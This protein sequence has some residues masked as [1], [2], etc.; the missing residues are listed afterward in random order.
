MGD[1]DNNF[2]ENICCSFSFRVRLKS[3]VNQCDGS[4]IAIGMSRAQQM[5]LSV[6]LKNCEMHAHYQKLTEYFCSGEKSCSLYEW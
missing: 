6:F 1:F 4:A 2:T 5:K 3:I